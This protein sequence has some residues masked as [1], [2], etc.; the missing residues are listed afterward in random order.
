MEKIKPIPSNWNNQEATDYDRKVQTLSSAVEASRIKEIDFLGKRYYTAE[1]LEKANQELA[2]IL[3]K[4]TGESEESAQLAEWEFV[5][6]LNHQETLPGCRARLASKYDDHRNGID[7]ICTLADEQGIDY[8]F[9]IDVT[10]STLKDNIEKKFAQG[11]YPRAKGQVPAG[12]SFIKF[13][14]DGN[15][16]ACIKGVP[17]FILGTSP[18]FNGHQKYLDKFHIQADGSV[19]HEPDPDLRFNIL[20]SLLIQSHTL[21]HNLIK[22]PT[23]DDAV[24]ERAIK[25]CSIVRSAAFDGLAELMQIPEGSNFSKLFD[26][27]FNQNLRRAKALKVNGHPD[28]SYNYLIN[29]AMKRYHQAVQ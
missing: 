22:N 6:A 29:E 13:Y 28:Y 4:Q 7:I 10:T 23:G 2:E 19:S 12:C 14:Q 16:H 9:G 25:T 8:I 18:L 20:S 17:R 15:R 1:Y 11:D 3:Q 27:K 5:Y 26:K 21:E 24:R